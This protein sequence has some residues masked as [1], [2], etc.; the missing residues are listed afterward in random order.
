MNHQQKY[1]HVITY[2]CKEGSCMSEVYSNDPQP[3][4]L[5]QLNDMRTFLEK[6]FNRTGVII[7]NIFTVTNK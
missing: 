2:K 3:Q 7:G 5:T 4:T 1:L 6:E